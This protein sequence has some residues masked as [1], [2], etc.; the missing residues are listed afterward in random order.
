MAML[1][2]PDTCDC[3]IEFD[4]DEGPDGNPE[5]FYNIKAVKTCRLHADLTGVELM[6]RVLDRNRHK[7]YVYL[8]LLEHGAPETTHVRYDPPDGETVLATEHGFDADK[9]KEVSA[10]LATKFPGKRIKV[11]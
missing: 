9:I 3:Q 4:L 7:E 6:R 1:W 11:V 10:R 5:D 8:E 2:L